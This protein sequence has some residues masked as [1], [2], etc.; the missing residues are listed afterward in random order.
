LKTVL[1]SKILPGSQMK[2]VKQSPFILSV[3]TA[4]E[5]LW[6]LSLLLKCLNL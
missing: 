2:S 4:I 5:S 1:I 6:S 3:V